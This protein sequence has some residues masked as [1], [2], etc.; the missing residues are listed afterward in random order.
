M[1]FIINFQNSILYEIIR[2]SMAWIFYFL[3]VIYIFY[4]SYNMFFIRK[5]NCKDEY[6]EKKK[7]ILNEI[8]ENTR[9][10]HQKNI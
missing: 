6:K 2:Q 7:Q 1:E 9:K 5:L 4:K 3:L 10:N 8:Q